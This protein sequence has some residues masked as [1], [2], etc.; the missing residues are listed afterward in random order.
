M[1]LFLKQSPH[2]DPQTKETKTKIVNAE[3]NNPSVQGITADGMPQSLEKT[4]Q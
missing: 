2:A 1:N 3:K 4:K